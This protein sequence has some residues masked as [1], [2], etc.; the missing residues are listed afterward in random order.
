MARL[1]GVFSGFVYELDKLAA[2][3][4]SKAKKPDATAMP[5][6]PLEAE[7]EQLTAQ[8][9]NLQLKMQL[10]QALQAQQAVA[11]QDQQAAEQQAQEQA[12]AQQSEQQQAQQAMQAPFNPSIA[13]SGVLPTSPT[14]MIGAQ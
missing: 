12:Q 1:S 8:L 10:R 2:A 4:D 3:S 13:A 9:E 14:D 7:N 6:S 11:A 5:P